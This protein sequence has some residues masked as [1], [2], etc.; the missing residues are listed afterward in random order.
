MK[1]IFLC[2][3]SLFI[4]SAGVLTAQN[5][6]GSEGSRWCSKRKIE[7]RKDLDKSLL[8]PHS[9]RHSFDV[10]NY[11]LNFDIFNCYTTPYPKSFTA[12]N[13]ITFKVDSTLSF[14]K[15]NAINS[16]LT[17]DSVRLAGISFTHS[18]D[19]LTITLDRV[20]NPGE[21][22]GVMIYYKHKNVSDNA[23]YVSSGF[24]FTDSEPE[25]ARKW[26]PCYDS[27]S[28]KATVDITAKVPLNAKLGSNGRLQDSTIVGSA[29]YYHWI[30]R[31]PVA[32]YLTVLTSRINYK[33]D[34]Y[35]WHKL[36]NPSESV[37]MRF[38]FN[39]GE[40]PSAME[41]II[42]PMTDLYSTKFGE[43]PFEKNGFATLNNQF[44]WGGMENQ[45]LTSLC[46]NCWSESLIAH[47]YAHQ[48]FGDMITC[49]SWA[50]IFLNEGFATFIEA[51]W[52]EDQYGH[53]AYMSEI[54]GNA[55]YYISYN[56]GWAISDP[57]WAVNTPST[58]ILFNYA[59]TYMKG[60]C[61]LH[62]LRYVLG[63]S[64]FFA[65]MKAYATDTVNFKYQSSTIGDF[66]DK[67]AEVSGQDLNWFFNEWIFQ[68]NHPYY[69]NLYS[70]EQL[71][72]DSWKV[73]FFARQTT[74]TGLLYYQMPL[75]IK[76]TFMDGSDTL[77]RVFNSYNDQYFTFSFDKQPA[78]L[79]FDPDNEIVLKEGTT[80]VGIDNL[81]ASYVES[82]LLLPSPNP[83]SG[84]T[85]LKYQLSAPGHVSL[86]VYDS[87]GKLVRELV[88]KNQTVG[89]YQIQFN[90]ASL[91]P[92]AYQCRLVTNA[93]TET[94]KLILQ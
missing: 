15:L 52:T 37:P 7:L 73:N 19:I 93:T 71:P 27:P 54:D 41:A 75:E 24:V 43:H 79:V 58:D 68:P 38:Y 56:P 85:I 90:G 83:F 78:S 47:E 76:I 10:I 8:S 63:D 49:G 23:F 91:S 92:G 2:S 44:A 84:S 18:G 61:V 32:T 77:V 22:A 45:T 14:I 5:L 87:Y 72:N 36:S 57:T 4:L 30:S 94:I 88:S 40:D 70:F 6:N 29:I 48:W 64:L 20:Y 86:N 69:R 13:L 1:K 12:S 59:I 21:T 17:I 33:L 31:D 55:G 89:S 67:M 42:G 3:L 26:F 16:S 28:D 53:Q 62:Q 34:I 65:G 9:P 46:P 74:Q 39:E 80:L 11:T 66:R 35:Y 60:S 50:D 51:I 25:G 81:S 82:R